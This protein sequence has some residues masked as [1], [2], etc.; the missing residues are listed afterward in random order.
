MLAF[1]L[2][3]AIIFAKLESSYSDAVVQVAG[4]I[5][6]THSLA[7]FTTIICTIKPY[8]RHLGAIFRNIF[9][10]IQTKLPET[11]HFTVFST[12]NRIYSIS[13]NS[14]H[15]SNWTRVNDWLLWWLL[16]LS[17]GMACENTTM[18]NVSHAGTQTG[19]RPQSY[20]KSFLMLSV[21]SG[22]ITFRS[23]MMLSIISV[24]LRYNIHF[25]VVINKRY[26][27]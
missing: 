17:K 6:S 18:I 13:D 8:R 19:P 27:I 3:V 12:S 16:S 1:P 2:I 9:V 4:I 7:E 10:A 5:A 21:T 24:F 20:P 15:L 14:N 26:K 23:S 22:W 11:W 25:C